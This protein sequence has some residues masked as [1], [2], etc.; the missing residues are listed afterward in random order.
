MRSYAEIIYIDSDDQARKTDMEHVGETNAA[1]WADFRDLR[2]FAVD[3][4]SARFLLDYYNAKGDLA[5]TIFIDVGG[6]VAITGS[7]PK[8]D[9]AYRA[10]D[11]QYWRD[12]RSA[13]KEL[14]ATKTQDVGLC[15]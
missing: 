15:V 10:I 4:A 14:P 12:A 13:C 6:F 3:K 7:Q 2:R 1:T 5:D 11:R 8:S 9:A